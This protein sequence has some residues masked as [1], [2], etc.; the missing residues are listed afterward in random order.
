MPFGPF[1][2]KFS[3]KRPGPRKAQSLSSLQNLDRAQLQRESTADDV[4]NK[5]RVNLDGNKIVF[6]GKD[7]ISG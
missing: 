5:I 2:K 3:L 4:G 1:A 6:D 7:W